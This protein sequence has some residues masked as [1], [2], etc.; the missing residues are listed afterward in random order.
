MS[1]TTSPPVEQAEA[2]SHEIVS[3][4]DLKAGDLVH[5]KEPFEARSLWG[6]EGEPGPDFQLV[7]DGTIYRVETNT[8]PNREP[9]TDGVIICNRLAPEHR[10]KVLRR[11]EEFPPAVFLPL[12]EDIEFLRLNGVEDPNPTMEGYYDRFINN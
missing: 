6:L 7:P 8:Y 11:A 4:D 10:T 1:E 9:F 12:Q 2:E 3:W 5:M